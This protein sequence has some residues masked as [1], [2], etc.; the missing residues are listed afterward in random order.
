MCRFRPVV[1]DAV[2]TEAEPVK[3]DYRVEAMPNPRALARIGDEGWELVAIDP[4][5]GDYIFKRSRPSFRERVTLEQKQRYFAVWARER[6][7]E[8]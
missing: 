4:K 2:M 7:S 1:K 5:N 3:W 6:A 8:S